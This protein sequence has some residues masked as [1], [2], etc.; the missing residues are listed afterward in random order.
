MTLVAKRAEIVLNIVIAL[1]SIGLIIVKLKTDHNLTKPSREFGLVG[2]KAALPNADWPARQRT[3]L[4]VLSTSCSFCTASM[5]FYRTLIPAAQRAKVRIV[6]AFPQ[7]PADAQ[8]YLGHHGLAI[9]DVRQAELSSVGSP[10]TPA[11]M[12]IDQ[13]GTVTNAWIGKL[14]SNEETE[15]LLVI[16]PSGLATLRHLLSLP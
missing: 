6:A 9:Q 2:T 1:S 3:I 16:K 4:F 8:A 7:S 10:G 5:P 14:S 12:M 15:V 11:L 13:N